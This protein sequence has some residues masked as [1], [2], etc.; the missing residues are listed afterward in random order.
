MLK[1]KKPGQGLWDLL[2]LLTTWLL[3]NENCTIAIQRIKPPSTS[4]A[5]TKTY[6]YF[7][8]YDPP[9]RQS[10][11]TATTV[12]GVLKKPAKAYEAIYPKVDLPQVVILGGG[13]AGFQLAQ[14]LKKQKYDGKC[15]SRERGRGECLWIYMCV[16]GC[17]HICLSD[18]PSVCTCILM[19]YISI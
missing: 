7:Y 19:C 3:S 12:A 8:P 17:A 4:G 2:I 11:T 15:L 5:T 10:S 18:M 14:D 13:W 1:M 6:A 16:R 9:H